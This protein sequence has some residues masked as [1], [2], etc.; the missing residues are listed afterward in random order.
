MNPRTAFPNPVLPVARLALHHG[1]ASRLGPR[2][3]AVLLGFLA[4]PFAQAQNSDWYSRKGQHITGGFIVS[5]AW[6]STTKKPVL[7]IA[8]AAA[9]GTLK[10]SYDR[11]AT[12]QP[13]AFSQ[14]D[15]AIT[16]LGGVAGAFLAHRF[17][18]V[19]QERAF[20]L[21]PKLA[22]AALPLKETAP[23]S[24]SPAAH[25]VEPPPPSAA[26]SAEYVPCL[27]SVME[28]IPIRIS[29]W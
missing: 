13:G 18:L 17:N 24:P 8:L 20:A 6:G 26:P 7:G 9:I 14:R 29:P 23:L 5:L 10:E 19:R 2:T 3:R 25:P 15:I 11:K 22:K 1:W 21:A 28:D 16:T 4:L 27:E 12:G